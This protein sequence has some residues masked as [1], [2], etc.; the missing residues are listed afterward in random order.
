M[1][2]RTRC[3]Q[4]TSHKRQLHLHKNMQNVLFYKFVR[5]ESLQE[6]RGELQAMM[7]ECHVK[8]KILIAKEGINGNVSGTEEACQQFMERLSSFEVFADIEY[9]IT[10]TDRHDF[11]KSIV[12]IRPE[13]IT[14]DHDWNEEDSADY[15]EP[16][17]L[18]ALYEANENFLIID[19]RNNYESRIGHFEGAIKPDIQVFSEWPDAIKEYAEHKDK[20]IVTYCTGGI[21]CEKASAVMKAA[22][23]SNVKQLRGGIIRY[24]QTVGREHWEGKCFVFDKRVAIDI[25]KDASEPIT[26]CALT[27]KP[28]A[29]YINC[30]NVACDK[31]F[32]CSEEGMERYG[33]CCSPECQQKLQLD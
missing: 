25:A 12:R 8:G 7:E 2:T 31:R 30:Q 21:R 11:R 20:L 32:L 1:C 3:Y 26:N 22:G 17:E 29:M 14:L 15:I 24:G 13:I 10:E 27:G 18:K 16:E 19:A 6:L 33:G 4:D 5:L 23:F 28:T 9:K